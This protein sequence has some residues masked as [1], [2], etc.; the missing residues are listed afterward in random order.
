MSAEVV[1]MAM[2]HDG[3]G[4]AVGQIDHTTWRHAGIVED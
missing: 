4:N 3:E 1:N 2:L